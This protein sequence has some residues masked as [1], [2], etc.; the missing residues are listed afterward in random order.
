MFK[1]A[2]YS[3][4]CRAAEVVHANCMCRDSTSRRHEI[5]VLREGSNRADSTGM[6]VARALHVTT[7]GVPLNVVAVTN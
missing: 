1:I 3:A 5:L 7:D 2:Q 4:A 6:F